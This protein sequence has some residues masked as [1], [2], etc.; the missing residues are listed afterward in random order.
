MKKSILFLLTIALVVA[1]V[2][3]KGSR[4]EGCDPLGCCIGGVTTIGLISS[5]ILFFVANAKCKKHKKKVLAIKIQ[6]EK[7][8]NILVKETYEQLDPFEMAQKEEIEYKMSQILGDA[9][10]PGVD[11]KFLLNTLKKK[12]KI[13]PTLRVAGVGGIIAS[14]LYCCGCCAL[15][16]FGYC[17]SQRRQRNRLQEMIDAKLTKNVSEEMDE[18]AED[19][20][21]IGEVAGGIVEDHVDIGQQIAA[22][23]DEMT[24]GFRKN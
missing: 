11:Y 4:V 1:P 7:L 22:M 12:G 6:I 8:K 18:Y 10:I 2:N 20:R 14:I 5:T 16:C 21:K 15:N 3:P 19:I 9:Y 24:G 13:W 17:A 23:G